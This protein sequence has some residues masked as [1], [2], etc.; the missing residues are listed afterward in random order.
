MSDRVQT[1][2]YPKDIGWGGSKQLTVDEVER[3]VAPW[4][5]AQCRAVRYLLLL[6]NALNVVPACVIRFERLEV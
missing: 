5:D 2:E 4:S 3:R 1:S 6:R